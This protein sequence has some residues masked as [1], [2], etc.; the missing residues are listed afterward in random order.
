VMAD[1]ISFKFIAAPLSK[2]QLAELIQI[3]ERR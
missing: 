2:D 3:P 1:A